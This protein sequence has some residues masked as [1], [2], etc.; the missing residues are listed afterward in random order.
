MKFI[1]A[2]IVCMAAAIISTEMIVY[3]KAKP[4][5]VGKITMD[6]RLT[7][8]I[9]KNDS[10]DAGVSKHTLNEDV[11]VIVVVKACGL[12]AENL[13]IMKPEVNY[14][15]K[16]SIF[17]QASGSSCVMKES[18]ESSFSGIANS[19]FPDFIS[20]SVLSVD[21]AAKTYILSISLPDKPIVIVTGSSHDERKHPLREIKNIGSPG[22]KEYSC[23]LITFT[24][25]IVYDLFTTEPTSSCDSSGNKCSSTVPATERKVPLMA[26]YKGEYDGGKEIK[27]EHF[28]P[29]SK[30]I[31]GSFK[32]NIDEIQ[33]GLI[34]FMKEMGK[35]SPELQKEFAEAEADLR[36]Q[37]AETG[38]EEEEKKNKK[39]PDLKTVETLNIRWKF[40]LVTECEDLI[41]ELKESIS[42]LRAYT[43][44]GILEKAADEG[45]DGTHDGDG[46]AYDDMIGR[47]GYLQYMAHWWD[48]DYKP[49]DN[50]DDSSIDPQ[51]A[52]DPD[53]GT[54]NDCEIENYDKVKKEYERKCYPG[55]MFDAIHEHEKLHVQQCSDDVTGPEYKSGTPKSYQ[56]YE[57]E[58]HC[59]SVG[60]VL[61]Y[62]KEHCKDCDLAP[63]EK[64][65]KRICG[66]E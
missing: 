14:I 7:N 65:Y 64:E 18:Y 11:S 23:E 29:D 46:K 13:R 36:K 60:M 8:S 20:Q 48:P 27:G 19:E 28:Y 42:V 45:I 31:Y 33:G 15:L 21:S 6:Y 26:S 62:T 17:R 34:A 57:L 16:E 66:G 37:Q 47:E 59:L 55:I 63:Y 35:S 61:D 10:N 49:P 43:D 22:E 1:I 3:A 4:Y 50:Q 39:D 52:A 41:D 53:M 44:E 24:T 56:K 38:D 40:D 12:S 30:S 9:L 58:A 25:D 2:I 54:N 32:V 51:G 5:W